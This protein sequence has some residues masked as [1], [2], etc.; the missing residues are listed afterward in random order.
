MQVESLQT[1]AK[2]LAK[3]NDLEILEDRMQK[4]LG[5]MLLPSPNKE[6]SRENRQKGSEGKIR[7]GS[8]VIGWDQV[9]SIVFWEPHVAGCRTC[10]TCR[11]FSPHA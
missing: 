6:L 9:C 1:F 5:L 10:R 4:A 11:V 7:K 2:T 8:E 3:Q